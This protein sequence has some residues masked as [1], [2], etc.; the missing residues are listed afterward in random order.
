MMKPTFTLFPVWVP[1][2]KLKD[3]VLKT[4]P[5]NGSTTVVFTF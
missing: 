1:S 5:W 2:A 4:V 3:K